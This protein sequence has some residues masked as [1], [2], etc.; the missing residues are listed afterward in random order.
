MTLKDFLLNSEKVLQIVDNQKTL[1]EHLSKIASF[2]SSYISLYKELRNSFIPKDPNASHNQISNIISKIVKQDNLTLAEINKMRPYDLFTDLQKLI[3]DLKQIDIFG[4]ELEEF[5]ES[6]LKN[7]INLHTDALSEKNFDKIFSFVSLC[8][9]FLTKLNRFK[10]SAEIFI[11]NLQP[12][13]KDIPE[14][15]EVIDIQIS[16][17]LTNLENFSI[18]LKFIDKLY[19]NLCKSLEIH[20]SDYP[21]NIIKIESGSCISPRNN[22]TKK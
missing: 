16:S 21:L 3:S 19:Q 20:Y 1:I 6:D 18:F 11:S 7:L 4:Q 15:N 2:N 17:H 22:W 8:N 14:Q 9:P 5:L 12:L 10:Y 13:Q